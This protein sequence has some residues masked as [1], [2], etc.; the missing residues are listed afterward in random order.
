MNGIIRQ[1]YNQKLRRLSWFS[2]KINPL[3]FVPQQEVYLVERFGAY[4]R[5][6]GGGPLF[7]IP[8]I[9]TISG[10]Q[11]KFFYHG[12][13]IYNFYFSFERNCYSHRSTKGY[14]E[15]QCCCRS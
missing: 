5:Q 13:L 7:K 11:G 2:K 15:R 6:K 4:S 12:G 14:H 9:E 1:T 10:V 3:L 8:L